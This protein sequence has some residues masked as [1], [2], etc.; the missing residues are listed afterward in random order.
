MSRLDFNRPSALWHAGAG[1]GP[2]SAVTSTPPNRVSFFLIAILALGAFVIH[3]PGQASVD[4]I[5]QL[6]DG[7]SAVYDS[8]QPPAMSFLMAK[9]ELPGMLALDILLFSLAVGQLIRLAE[10]RQLVQYSSVLLLFVFPVFLIYLGTVWKDVLFAHAAVFAFLLLPR[11]K[12]VRWPA[13]L[14]SAALLALGAAVRQQGLLVVAFAMFYLL[15]ASGLNR[16]RLSRWRI[17]FSW[18]VVYVLCFGG[19][20]LAVVTSGDT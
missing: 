13:L 10:P 12:E 16:S 14:L 20:K 15:F 9:L 8:N 1:Q 4:A 3:Y 6:D 5:L 17:L 18:L 2:R 19:I 7:M 11:G